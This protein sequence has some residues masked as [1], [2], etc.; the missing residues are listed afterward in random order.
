MMVHDEEHVLH[1]GLTYWST[2]Y[3]TMI[4]DVTRGNSEGT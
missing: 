3:K 1:I 2:S 4:N